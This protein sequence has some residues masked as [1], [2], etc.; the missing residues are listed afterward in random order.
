MKE[1]PLIRRII[2]ILALT[3]VFISLPATAGAQA[4]ES[5]PNV[6]C[7]SHGRF[8][9]EVEWRDFAGSTGLGQAVPYSDTT[10]MFWF[11]D[12]QTLDMHVDV[13]DGC[14][15]T[16]TYWFFAAASTNVEYA[17]RVTDTSDGT[18]KTYSNALGENAQAI[19]DTTAFSCESPDNRPA[20]REYVTFGV[21][22]TGFNRLRGLPLYRFPVL[23][24]LAAQVGQPIDFAGFETV[25]AYDAD[26]GQG[27][28]NSPPITPATP[29]SAILASH[30]D[31]QA[32]A[33]LGVNI[34]NVPPR[35]LNVKLRDMPVLTDD[36]GVE[37]TR[38]PCATE[39]DN[40]LDIVHA[41]PCEG[42]L[43]LE[44]WLRARGAARVSCFED[45]TANF[46]LRA[47][48]L[49]PNRMYSAWMVM[50]NPEAV[51]PVP[52][53]KPVPVGGLPNIFVTDAHGNAVFQRRLG[54]CPQDVDLALA[55]AIHMR[56][57]HQNYGGVPEPF[58]NQESPETFFPTFAGA[59][60]GTVLHIQMT[61]N[62][63]GV[64][65]RP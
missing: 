8:Q 37:E 63:N 31:V 18:T 3:L 46:I 59:T 30:L 20:V 9:V 34:E 4:C 33:P 64:P 32:M 41:S 15:L 14:P 36:F 61:F 25:G 47:S 2:L 60:P 12:S 22:S 35:R 62:V 23:E 44:D 58:L 54:F 56:A 6:L 5:S 43:T 50:F 11:F 55:F 45:G 28:G 26:L 48:N 24:P 42:D 29:G 21:P 16:G 52:F 57:N 40:P 10:G 27:G 39:S 38:I 53:L 65:A 17:L 7:L 19:T 49:V 51:F 13:I 1:A